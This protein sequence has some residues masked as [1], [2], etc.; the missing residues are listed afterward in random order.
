MRGEAR[1]GRVITNLLEYVPEK[2]KQDAAMNEFRAQML[3]QYDTAPD[4]SLW[5]DTVKE[6]RTLF[7]TKLGL[8]PKK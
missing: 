4:K 1:L 6:V 7:E 2:E 5:R 3:A 8:A